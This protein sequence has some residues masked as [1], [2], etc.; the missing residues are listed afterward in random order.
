MEAACSL[1][2]LFSCSCLLDAEIWVGADFAAR[3]SAPA[4]VDDRRASSAEASM[5][6]KSAPLRRATLWCCTSGAA[7]FT[8]PSCWISPLSA[9]IVDAVVVAVVAGMEVGGDTASR[10]ERAA[11]SAFLCFANTAVSIFFWR[12]TTSVMVYRYL[13]GINANGE[14]ELT[15]DHSMCLPAREVVRCQTVDPKVAF[16]IQFI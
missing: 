15:Y 1:F 14:V 12:M 16:L 5:D 6:A 11:S 3:T 2:L 13:R 10:A 8:C 9:S 7:F 4:T